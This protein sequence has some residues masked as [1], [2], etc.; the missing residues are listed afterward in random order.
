MRKYIYIDNDGKTLF[1]D[2]F[3][4]D[5]PRFSGIFE[6]SEKELSYMVFDG[7]GLRKDNLLYENYV[8]TN[9]VE[10]KDYLKSVIVSD[11]N[12]SIARLKS[13]YPS[14][15]VT[16]WDYKSMQAKLWI[17]SD[18][19][20]WLID[21]DSVLMLENESD[22]TIEGITILANRIIH[23][24]NAYQTIYGKNTRKYKELLALV[25]ACSTIQ[26][27]TDLEGQVKYD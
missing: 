26:E 16:G 10:Y 6:V 11:Y 27:L 25:N 18:D 19:K 5:R 4:K 8:K 21:N 17:D 13:A 2:S 12:K 22:G 9:L 1:F 20:Q 14:E 7:Y 3:Q 15:E 24:S 23:N